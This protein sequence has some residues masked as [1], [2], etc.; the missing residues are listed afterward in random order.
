MN[1]CLSAVHVGLETCKITQ[2]PLKLDCLLKT[3]VKF[4]NCLQTEHRERARLRD[5]SKELDVRL[6]EL[7]ADVQYKKK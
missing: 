4:Q 5:A 6:G 1:A 7:I 2:E 3:A